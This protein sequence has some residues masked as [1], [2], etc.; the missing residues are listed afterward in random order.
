[1]EKF[2]ISKEDL[3]QFLDRLEV[4]PTRIQDLVQK[5][6][7]KMN[8]LTQKIIHHLLQLSLNDLKFGRF[9]IGVLFGEQCKLYFEEKKMNS[10]FEEIK[11][12]F[13]DF[14][15][16]HLIKAQSLISEKRT[17]EDHINLNQ[18]MKEVKRSLQSFEGE[19][20]SKHNKDLTLQ[21]AQ[22]NGLNISKG[23]NKENKKDNIY[24]D[25]RMKMEKS[26]SITI[27]IMNKLNNSLPKP[28]TILPPLRKIRKSFN[29]PC[30]P[31]KVAEEMVSG[32]PDLGTIFYDLFQQNEFPDEYFDHWI[33]LRQ[34]LRFY[35]SQLDDFYF[36]LYR[37]QKFK[38]NERAYSPPSKGGMYPGGSPRRSQD[39]EGLE[40]FERGKRNFS[41]FLTRNGLTRPTHD[42]NSN[43]LFR[44]MFRPINY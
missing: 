13:L 8:R 31:Q 3:L 44:S 1:M 2:K 19:S 12:D 36:H 21:T 7:L 9:M 28:Q 35:E 18:K 43:L 40:R 29:E 25:E 26:N 17:A 24:D 10:R 16:D 11:K 6:Y 22:S 32:P 41:Q 23:W 20:G 4:I 38:K 5:E 42:S 15:N 34:K 33:F 14:V 39:F 37:L 27:N 30:T